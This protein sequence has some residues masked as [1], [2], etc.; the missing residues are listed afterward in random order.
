M[1]TVVVLVLTTVL[2]ADHP[3]DRRSLTSSKRRRGTF[4][5]LGRFLPQGAQLL[6]ESTTTGKEKSDGSSC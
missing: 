2:V 3:W 5:R 4:T 1:S 6:N